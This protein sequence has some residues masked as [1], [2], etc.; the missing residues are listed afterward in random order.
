V[1]ST[2]EYLGHGLTWAASTLLFLW[3][4]S[5]ADGWLGTEPWLTLAGAFVGAGAGF[6][7]M[8]HQLSSASRGRRDEG[9]E[10]ARE[11]RQGR[12]RE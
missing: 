8:V 11:E 7:S 10:R 12:E 5:E 2:S 6:Y 1:K 3:L 9:D 4:G